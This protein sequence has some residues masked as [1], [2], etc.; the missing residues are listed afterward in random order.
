MWLVRV[1][2]RIG[3]DPLGLDLEIV[4]THHVVLGIKR[5]SPGEQLLILS[6]DPSLQLPS[7]AFIL[8]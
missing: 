3:S 4:V 6:A 5:R 1:K 2:V 8:K 7:V